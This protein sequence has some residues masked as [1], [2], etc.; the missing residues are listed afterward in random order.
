VVCSPLACL[1][2]REFIVLGQECI[3][4]LP[5]ERSH[6]NAATR[7]GNHQLFRLFFKQLDSRSHHAYT[8]EIMTFSEKPI[9]RRCNASRPYS[10]TRP[11][12]PLDTGQVWVIGDGG[13]EDAT[14]P[15]R[16]EVTEVPGSGIRTRRA[17]NSGSRPQGLVVSD[18]QNLAHH[19]GGC[20]AVRISRRCAAHPGNRAARRGA[21]PRKALRL[22]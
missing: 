11:P 17:A 1:L 15:Y 22:R 16:S 8:S 10:A 13:A 4:A 5:D 19:H 12:D 9:V 21:P 14:G 18:W 2:R 6:R 7:C 20:T 3:D